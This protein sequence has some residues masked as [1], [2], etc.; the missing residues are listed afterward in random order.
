V[1]QS[2]G[3]I[4]TAQQQ[5]CSNDISLCNTNVKNPFYGVLASN[6]TLGASSTIPQWE[7]QRAYP[8]FNGVSEQRLPQGSSHFNSL[9]VRVERR[10][11]SLDFVFNYAY[12]NW[13]DKLDYLNSG[14][15][16]DPAPTPQLDTAD[17]RNAYTLNAVYPLPSTHKRGFVGEALNGWLVSS[18]FI[19]YTGTPLA[20]PAAD[21]HCASLLP[22]GGQTRAHW[23]NN[24]ESCWS[25]LG[26]W[27]A[28]TLPLRIG[29]IRNPAISEWNPG[30]YKQFG[31]PWR[32]MALQFRMQALNGAN[33]P[34]WGAPSTALAT[35]P[36]YSAKTSWTGFG[37]L[38][39]SQSNVPRTILSSLKIIF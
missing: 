2:L 18:T 27:E 16:Q 35:P 19:Y 17:V 15:F 7:L 20:L 34:T 24:D 12:S 14:N 23:F 31:L 1:T 11:R 9:A 38:P 28:R 29:V 32:D 22:D 25:N 4:S 39:T 37:T 5:A 30:F 13:R 8:L 6:T 26:T 36:S 10:V 33:H 3:V 21:F